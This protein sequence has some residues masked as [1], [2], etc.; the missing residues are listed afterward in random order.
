[1]G[2]S[3]VFGIFGSVLS[4]IISNDGSIIVKR[5]KQYKR[6]LQIIYIVLLVIMGSYTL[7]L[8]FKLLPLYWI[9]TGLLGLFVFPVLSILIE[10]SC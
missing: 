10:Y 3:L 8:N 7:S 6:T 1:M 2:V 4:G 5:N 9:S